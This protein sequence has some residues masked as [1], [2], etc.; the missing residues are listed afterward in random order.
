MKFY[1]IWCEYVDRPELNEYDLY[2]FT[3][4]EAGLAYIAENYFDCTVEELEEPPETEMHFTP[5]FALCRG[6]YSVRQGRWGKWT[7][8]DFEGVKVHAKLAV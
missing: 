6:M 4:E 7:P 2:A 1:R 5:L 3:D 8:E